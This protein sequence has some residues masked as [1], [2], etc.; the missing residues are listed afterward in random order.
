MWNEPNSLLRRDCLAN[1][2]CPFD[3]NMTAEVFFRLHDAAFHTLRR[4]LLLGCTDN[5]A[6]CATDGVQLRVNGLPAIGVSGAAHLRVERIQ[7]SGRNASR[8]P[9]VVRDERVSVPTSGPLVISLETEAHDVVR[10][11]IAVL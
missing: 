4:E 2:K 11:T 5:S 1:P 10:V 7:Y 9:A 6:P 8:A 3:A